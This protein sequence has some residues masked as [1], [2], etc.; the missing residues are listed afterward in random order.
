MNK[1]SLYKILVGVIFFLVIVSGYFINF[2]NYISFESIKQG[3]Q[4][5]KI[6][7]NNNFYLYYFIF[8]LL[9]IMVVSLALP[10]AVPTSLLAGAL[11]GFIPGI[12]LASF[13][14]SIGSTLCFL[15]SRFIFRDYVQ[16]KFQSY[17]AKINKGI[18]DE[19][20]LY[21]FFLRLNPIFPF[22]AV[23]LVFGITKMNVLTFY[24]VSQIGMLIGSA[25]FVNAG[26]QISNISSVSEILSAKLI[27]SLLFIGLFPLVLK[28][29]FFR[30]AKIAWV[31]MIIM[32]L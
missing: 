11:F 32:W 15:L 2:E 16:N 25:I 6:L 30:K 8:F 29:I 21:L 7:I 4:N 14:S 17:L 24:I 13:A 1:S 18:N 31:N 19:G 22:F 5:L 10:I 28:K 26:V 23:N 3:H 9:Y 12:I 20:W 27:I